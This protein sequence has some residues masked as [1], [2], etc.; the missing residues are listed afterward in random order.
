[1]ALSSSTND[2][3]FSN[4]IFCFLD[5]RFSIDL[6][7]KTPKRLKTS[8]IIGSSL[9]L[10]VHSIACEPFLFLIWLIAFS[11]PQMTAEKGIEPRLS[12]S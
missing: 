11:S 6:I 12:L 3:Q 9:L 8:R 7:A 1:M 5:I 4:V 2:S 10:N